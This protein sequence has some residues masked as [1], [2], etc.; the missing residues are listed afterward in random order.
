MQ[1]DELVDVLGLESD[2]IGDGYES[3][4]GQDVVLLLE[5]TFAEQLLYV[6]EDCCDVMGQCLVG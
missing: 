3:I 6:V 2:A 1:I 4:P 5:E